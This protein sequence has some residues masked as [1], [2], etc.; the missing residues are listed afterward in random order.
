MC[1]DL[2]TAKAANDAHAAT[3]SKRSNAIACVFISIVHA[4]VFVLDCIIAQYLHAINELF[5]IFDKFIVELFPKWNHF[6]NAD[7]LPTPA[8]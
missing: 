8:K 5:R 3:A 4:C 6:A 1:F 2:F 7:K